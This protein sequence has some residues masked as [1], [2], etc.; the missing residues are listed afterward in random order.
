MYIVDSGAV[1]HHASREIDVCDR[2]TYGFGSRMDW[3]FI[4]MFGRPST[5]G[6][7]RSREQKKPKHA[8]R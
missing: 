1:P 6:S 5:M 8:E 2:M 3:R 4:K 7:H